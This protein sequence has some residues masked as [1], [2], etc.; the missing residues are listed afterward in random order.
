MN[1]EIHTRHKAFGTCTT[2]KAMFA[3]RKA[4]KK[5]IRK[6]N[7]KGKPY[8]CNVCGASH[9]TTRYKGATAYEHN[10]RQIDTA[11]A[12]AIIKKDPALAEIAELLEELS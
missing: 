2:G 11:S 1:K 3:D 6:K 12:R 5:Y 9:I 7:L 10:V 4:A 8:T